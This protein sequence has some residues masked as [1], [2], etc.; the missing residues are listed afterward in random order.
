MTSLQ[1]HIEI[2]LAYISAICCPINAEFGLR[3]HNHMLTRVT[4][5][6]WQTSEIQDGG[7]P[8]VRKCIILCISTA[9]HPISLKAYKREFWLQQWR[10]QSKSKFSKSKLADRRHI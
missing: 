1:I 2:F 6:K 3:E 5:Q 4:W 9:N 7:R 10:R 8:P